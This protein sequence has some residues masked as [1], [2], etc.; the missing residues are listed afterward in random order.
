[1]TNRPDQFIV[2]TDDALGN[3]GNAMVG[4]VQLPNVAGINVMQNDGW[5]RAIR[6][7]ACTP[8]QHLE[9]SDQIV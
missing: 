5:I 3:T 1:M 8:G 6:I 9:G 2:F 7:Q 4:H